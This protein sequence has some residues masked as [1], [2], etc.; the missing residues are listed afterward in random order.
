M[1]FSKYH[2]IVNG[3]PINHK[4]KTKC[5]LQI[6]D[7]SKCISC[8]DDSN[9]QVIEKSNVEERVKKYKIIL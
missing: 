1:P 5:E 6:D 7:I 4:S 3:D 8:E 9:C 2:I